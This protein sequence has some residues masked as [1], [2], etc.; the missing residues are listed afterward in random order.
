MGLHER[1][2]LSLLHEG[3]LYV[4][5]HLEQSGLVHFLAQESIEAQYALLDVGIIQGEGSHLLTECR[6]SWQNFISEH[7]DVVVSHKVAGILLQ[8]GMFCLR[9]AGVDAQLQ[10]PSL[11]EQ[12]VLS[13]SGY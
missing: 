5:F 1:F 3:T 2:Q 4:L 8:A 9:A 6:T 13:L 11:L 12:L 10:R 7:D